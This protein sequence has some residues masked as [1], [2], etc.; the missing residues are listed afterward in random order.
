LL[1]NRSFLFSVGLHKFKK[2]KEFH[3]KEILM[4]LKTKSLVFPVCNFSE[5]FK[6][7]IQMFNKIS[8]KNFLGQINLL[9]LKKI[10]SNNKKKLTKKIK[11]HVAYLT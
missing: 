6:Y 2:L 9:F 11:S 5:N 8:K 10:K 1:Q 3:L 4:L 7:V